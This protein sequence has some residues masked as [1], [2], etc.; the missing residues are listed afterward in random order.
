ML[1]KKQVEENDASDWHWGQ[2][3]LY[4]VVSDVQILVHNPAKFYEYTVHEYIE[5]NV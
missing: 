4:F 2:S 5:Y 3:N 1:W